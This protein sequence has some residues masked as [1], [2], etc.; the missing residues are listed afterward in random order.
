MGVIP[1]PLLLVGKNLVSGLYLDELFSCSQCVLV[2]F[3]R[4]IFESKS[5]IRLQ[6]R[7]IR[8]AFADGRDTFFMSSAVVVSDL[9]T[10]SIS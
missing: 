1:G 5:T 2:V 10:S 7:E 8:F 4:M 3:V 6:K 9:T